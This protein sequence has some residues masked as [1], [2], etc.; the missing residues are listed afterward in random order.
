MVLMNLFA[1]QEQRCRGRNGLE[2]TVGGGEG[3]TNW[4]SSTHVCTLPR[5]K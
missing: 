5:V 3:K 1:G 4:E 2:D